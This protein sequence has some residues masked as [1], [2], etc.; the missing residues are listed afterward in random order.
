MSSVQSGSYILMF[1]DIEVLLIDFPNSEFT[2][3]N[4][5]YVPYGLKNRIYS[6]EKSDY[7]EMVITLTTIL[8]WFESRTLRH[9]RANSDKIYNALELKHSGN[10][11]DKFEFSITHH[12]VCAGDKYWVKE[13]DD[14]IQWQCVN[15]HSNPISNDMR[16]AALYGSL[17][18]WEDGLISPEITTGGK[19]A[20]AWRRGADD[21]LWLDKLSYLGDESQKEVMVSGILDKCN[22]SHVHYDVGSTSNMCTC[23]CIST[24]AIS[25]L[26]AEEY[27]AYCGTIDTTLYNQTLLIDSDNYYKMCI[28]DYLIWNTDRH[29]RNYGFMYD[30]ETMM[31]IGL[32]PLFDHNKSFSAGMS[33]NKSQVMKERALYAMQNVDFHF[34]DD[35]VKSDFIKDEYYEMFTR[36]ADE[37]G[38]RTF[39]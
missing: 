16:S 3:L 30:N 1:G 14:P 33:P 25:I 34:T 2:I 8:G 26:T 29:L 32:H 23:P 11:F 27:A 21:N 15:V 35:I 31:I 5:L 7:K 28:V 13:S 17:S 39:K 36:R 9:S 24:D 6:D 37:I 38:V 20:K 10:M 19:F 12:S 18:K 22:V 4:D